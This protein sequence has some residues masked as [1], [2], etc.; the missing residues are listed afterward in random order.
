MIN[1]IIFSAGKKVIDLILESHKRLRPIPNADYGRWLERSFIIANL[2]KEKGRLLDVGCGN[3]YLSTM[4]AFLGFEV[5][6]LDVARVDCIVKLANL[7][8]IQ[9]DILDFYPGKSFDVIVACSTIEHIGVSGR[10]GQEEDE[11]A[12]LKAMNVLSLMV[13]KHG[14]LLLT[15]P[16]GR[17]T[18]LRPY[19]RVYGVQRLPLLLSR[20]EVVASEFWH[21]VN[22]VV[23]EQVEEDTALAVEGSSHY[24]ALGLFSLVRRRNEKKV[25]LGK[26]NQ[27]NAT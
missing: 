8:F 2:P 13:D 3:G 16:V 1:K 23:W 22:N 25:H 5:I 27:T 11:V 15:I 10:Y 12:D 17:D 24:L 18:I 6:G 14:T 9:A 19:C 4:A 20:F 26:P 21:K 7:S